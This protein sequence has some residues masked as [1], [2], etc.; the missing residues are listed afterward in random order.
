MLS[1]G[2]KQLIPNIMTK[3]VV[4]VLESIEIQDQELA[5]TRPAR[6]LSFDHG[7]KLI[8]QEDPIRQT[9]QIVVF[10]QKP[11]S[12]FTANL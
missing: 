7:A 10:S 9:C 1:N 12:L 11:N 5:I 2:D 8:L 3:R 6:L 4:D